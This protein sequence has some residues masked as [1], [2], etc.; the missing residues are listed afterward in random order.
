VTNRLTRDFYAQDAE[1]LAR[2]LLGKYLVHE[3]DGRRA[4]GRIVE[5]EAYV[6]PEDLACH[7]AK[8]LTPRTRVMFGPPGHAYVFVVYGRNHCFNVV[9]EREGFPAAV[10]VRALEPAEGC[11]AHPNGPAKLSRALG[12]T[13]ADTGLDLVASHLFLEDR[14]ERAAVEIV[15]TPRIGVDYAGEWADALL[16]FVDGRSGWLSKRVPGSPRGLR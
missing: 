5:T 8:G 4:A 10:L 2:E 7:A 14:G 12:I 3:R 1:A 16:R 13:V 6:G 11:D 9:C 15:A